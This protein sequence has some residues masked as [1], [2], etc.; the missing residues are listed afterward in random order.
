MT[1]DRA[2]VMKTLALAWAGGLLFTLSLFA[3]GS[4]GAD[5]LAESLLSVGLVVAAAGGVGAHD[6]DLYITVIFVDSV[7]YGGTIW[8]VIALVKKLRP[9]SRSQCEVPID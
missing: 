8:G 1:A 5:A 6:L 3:L 2:R 7:L 9:K 4:V